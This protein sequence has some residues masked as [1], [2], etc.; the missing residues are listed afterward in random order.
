LLEPQAAQRDIR[1][2]VQMP[3]PMR[4]RADGERVLQILLNLVGNA[5]KYAPRSGRVDVHCSSEG[6]HALIG[7]HDSG[8]GVPVEARERIFQPYVQLGSAPDARVAGAGLGLAISREL[9]RAM[10][11][12]LACVEG[13]EHGT[14]FVLR[15]PRS[16]GL[17][18]SEAGP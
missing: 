18:S 16:T 4:L 7:V 3:E 14:V 13:K 6:E 5:L 11:G 1:L 9:A 15:L 2:S 10:G 8:P 17:A 12:D